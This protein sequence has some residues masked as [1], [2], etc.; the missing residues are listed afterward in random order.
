[1]MHITCSKLHIA[2]CIWHIICT[3]SHTRMLHAATCI[4]HVTCNMFHIKHYMQPVAHGV[5]Y[6]HCR[7]HIYN[8]QEL[9][10]CKILIHKSAVQDFYD[11]IQGKLAFDFKI[12]NE[13]RE[14]L[15]YLHSKFGVITFR[16]TTTSTTTTTINQSINR[17]NYP[18]M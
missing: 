15:D 7:F 17:S 10:Y 16:P 12:S 9:T 14:K 13:L 8:I 6:A 18:R 5:L 11:E 1:M 4:L 3:M 2:S